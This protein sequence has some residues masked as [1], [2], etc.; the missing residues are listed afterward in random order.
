MSFWFSQ[1]NEMTVCQEAPRKKT[2]TIE[3]YRLFIARKLRAERNLAVDKELL[4]SLS[5]SLRF[6]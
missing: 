5:L 3:T 4:F 6:L 1:H 2:V